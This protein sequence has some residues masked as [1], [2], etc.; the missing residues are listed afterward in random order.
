MT[1]QN[2]ALNQPAY[3]STG[4]DVPLNNNFGYLDAA[5]GNTATVSN[6]TAYT[7]AASE[8]QCMRL[9][10]NG[11]L[12]SDLTISVPSGVGGFWIVT[13]AT[14]DASSAIP[15]YLTINTT[16]GGSLGVVIPKA[17]SPAYRESFTIFSDGT[18]V[19]FAFSITPAGK[20]IQ[21]AGTSA[22]TGYIACDGSA[23]SRSTY[24]A[25]FSAISTTW[26]SGNGTTTFNVPD[27]RGAF[28]RGSGT[29]SL[30]PNSP[31]AVGSFQA[32]AYLSHTHTDSGHTH[33]TTSY[34]LVGGGGT[35]AGNPPYYQTTTGFTSGTGYASIQA[36]GGAETRPDNYAVLMCIKT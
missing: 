23:I 12:S 21:Y 29:S 2:K 9:R 7:L 26:G 35:F 24:S 34:V 33:S 15:C 36:S 6:T 10:F 31:R 20:V 22:P 14:T 5:F 19:N 28:L 18:N 30:D 32:E 8:Y 3:N 13:N 16:A 17:I 11:S 1:T 25:L 4:W 27:L